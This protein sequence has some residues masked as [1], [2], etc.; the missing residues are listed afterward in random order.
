MVYLAN[1]VELTSVEVIDG[2]SQGEK[3]IE[4][5]GF[6]GQVSTAI[7]ARAFLSTSQVTLGH[8]GVDATTDL[9]GQREWRMKNLTRLGQVEG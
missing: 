8:V 9:R 6:I 2:C 3:R 1:L 7:V 4:R 5:D